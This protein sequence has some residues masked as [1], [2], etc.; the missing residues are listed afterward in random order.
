LQELGID[1]H[2]SISRL[3]RAA[4]VPGEA[5][6]QRAQAET[7]VRDFAEK[8]SV[9]LERPW[10]DAVREVSTS[11]ADD[12]VV[13]LDKAV[14]SA[15]VTVPTSAVWWRV[16]NVVQWALLAA[17]ILGGVWWGL[18]YLSD[19]SALF[20]QAGPEVAGYRL[21][22][23]MTIVGLAGGIGLSVLSR[24]A[25]WISGKTLARTAGRDLTEAIEA[26]ADE[27]VI[28]PVQEELEA[29]ARYR[30]NIIRARG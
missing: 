8:A 25:A 11:R 17:F 13:S 18:L 1:P 26:V 30:T 4:E 10:R 12:I 21:A 6:V 23:V 28:E 27:R 5:N 7:A 3:A 9:G 16:V 22:V 14:V 19:R 24:V 15:D 29:Y 20:V 2:H